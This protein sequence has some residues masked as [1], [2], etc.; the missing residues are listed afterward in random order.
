MWRLTS[1]T[2]LGLMALIPQNAAL[3]LAQGVQFLLQLLQRGLDLGVGEIRQRLRLGQEVAQADKLD[4]LLGRRLCFTQLNELRKS[5]GLKR[6]QQFQILVKGNQR[7]ARRAV[8]G[9]KSRQVECFYGT[10]KER[11]E[12]GLGFSRFKRTVVDMLPDPL[13]SLLICCKP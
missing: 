7:G 3:Q 11:H 8:R 9:G 4:R 5:A 6:G 2:F 12:R 10:A 13:E 1:K